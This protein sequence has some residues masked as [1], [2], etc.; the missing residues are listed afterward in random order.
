M[1]MW[2]ARK[3]YPKAIERLKLALAASPNNPQLVNDQVNILLEA[4]DF[5]SVVA[6]TDQLLA[7]DKNLV[8]ALQARAIAK[9]N[10]NDKDG[11]I[12]DFEAA[13]AAANA[14]RSDESATNVVRT[15][16]SEIGVDEALKR[17]T[18]RAKTENRWRL[19]AAH[20]YQTKGDAPAAAEMIE[21]TLAEYD[22]LTPGEKEAALRFAGT[23]YLSMQPQRVEKAHDAYVKL[24]QLQPN[25]LSSLNNMACLL[26]ESMTPPRPQEAIQ[27]STRA[28]D[29]MMNSGVRE[30]LIM[31]TQGWVLTL[32]GQVDKG[33]DVLRQA[34]A[35]R[36]FPDAHYHLAEA[37]LK[38]SYPEEAQKQLDMAAQ[39]VNQAKE[40]KQQF[41]P[42]LEAKIQDAQARAKEMI[43]AKSEAKVP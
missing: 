18:E 36:S 16:A 32:N 1:L 43:R 7:A 9:R 34:V 23:L 28:Y 27:Y 41:D 17:V 13:L 8:W 2:V 11:A 39:H 22:K 6:V 24:L 40:K 12:A 33:I 31:D 30:P 4:K 25:D 14:Q 35:T 29:L 5:K 21:R 26:A 42:T 3:D 15:M 20:L 38:K 19:V 10:L 37:Y